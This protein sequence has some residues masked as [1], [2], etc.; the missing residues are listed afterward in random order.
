MEFCRWRFCK[1]AVGKKTANG[2][3]LKNSSK[4]IAKWRKFTNRLFGCIFQCEVHMSKIALPKG[5][6][7][8]LES[9]FWGKY[10]FCRKTLQHSCKEALE[11]ASR[12]IEAHLTAEREEGSI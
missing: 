12:F 11:A 8:D 2:A 3:K 1:K 5:V 4:C 7:R 10:R 9:F 6:P